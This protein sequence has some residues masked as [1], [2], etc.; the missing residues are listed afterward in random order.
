[1]VKGSESCLGDPV[2]L[3]YLFAEDLLE[4]FF[5]FHLAFSCEH[6]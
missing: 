4:H 6:T 1:M 3:D 5:H 2:R